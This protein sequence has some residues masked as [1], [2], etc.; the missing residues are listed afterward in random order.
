MALS[1]F[2]NCPA[3][4]SCLENAAARAFVPVDPLSPGIGIDLYAAQA[5]V[6]ATVVAKGVANRLAAVCPDGP[7]AEEIDVVTPILWGILGSQLKTKIIY[8][9]RSWQTGL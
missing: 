8:H 3:I 4:K 6:E 2:K 7:S 5:A 1:C 9:C